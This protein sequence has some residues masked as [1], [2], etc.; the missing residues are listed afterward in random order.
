[1]FKK[2][3]DITVQAKTINIIAASLL[4][5]VGVLLLAV[6]DMADVGVKV[7]MGS[8]CVM[9]GAAKLL[10]YFS[11][12]MYRLA[13]QFDFAMGV[14]IVILGVLT[15]AG[16]W[17]TIDLL[18]T[19]FG[20]YVLLDGALKVQTAIDAKRFGMSQWVLMLISA[21]ILCAVGAFTTYVSYNDT[22]ASPTLL[23][24]IALIIDSTVNIWITAY[25]VRVRKQKK[26]ILDMPGKDGEE[27]E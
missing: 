11:N 27:N 4:T 3:K 8:L 13:F 6:P 20:I 26:G 24:G 23:L 9:V 21:I 14:L 17:K 15:I 22:I 19:A 10:G 1:M 16:A 2:K 25:T 7:M 18:P 12:D 5:V